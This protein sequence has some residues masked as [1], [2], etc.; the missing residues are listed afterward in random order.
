M[1][2]FGLF[3]VDSLERYSK[4]CEQQ[5]QAMKNHWFIK[6]YIYFLPGISIESLSTLSTLQNYRITDFF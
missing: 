2:G 1:L 5:F 3:L 6:D 4:I